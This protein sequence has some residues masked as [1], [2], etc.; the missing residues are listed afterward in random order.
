MRQLP[1]A[2]QQQTSHGGQHG[3]QN[4]AQGSSALQGGNG[5][6]PASQF[7]P[8]APGTSSD[9]WPADLRWPNSTGSQ[10]ASPVRWSER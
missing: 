1:A 3:H 8:P 5:F 10:P 9:G 2:G 6:G 4:T 7:V